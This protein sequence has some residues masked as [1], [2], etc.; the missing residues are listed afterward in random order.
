[1]RAFL[2]SPTPIAIS[3]TPAESNFDLDSFNA[4]ASS[5]LHKTK[6]SHNNTSRLSHKKAKKKKKT[7]VMS[8]VPTKSLQSHPPLSFFSIKSPNFPSPFPTCYSLT[9]SPSFFTL[10]TSSTITP[11]RLIMRASSS[12]DVGANVGEILGDVSIFTAAGEPVVFKDLWDQK[13]V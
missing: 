13:E 12:S 9:T 6:P 11:S 7:M 5:Q 3:L 2:G 4:E 10:T 8:M 1:M